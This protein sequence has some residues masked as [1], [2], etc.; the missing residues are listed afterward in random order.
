MKTATKWIRVT[1]ASPCPVCLKPDYC[2]YSADGVVARCMR[3][4]SAKESNGGWIHMLS[5]PRRPLPPPMPDR[6]VGPPP[7]F[8]QIMDALRYD[9]TRPMLSALA[10]S[11]GVSISALDA[12]DASWWAA[13][14][15]W[16]F[17]MLDDTGKAVGVRLRNDK[18]RKWAIP[19]SKQGLF[20]D[21]RMKASGDRVFYVCEGPTDTAALLT[22]GYPACG[23]AS[24][25]GQVDHV[26]G[27]CERLGF[28]RLII[29]SDNDAAKVRHDGSLWY[30]GAEGARA[31]ADA[32]G[33][34]Y[35]IVLPPAKDIRQWLR[36]GAT[37]AAFDCIERQQLW[38][39]SPCQAGS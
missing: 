8:A 17:P 31:L 3:V 7:D 16:A 1:K 15:T 24:C 2:G 39:K 28:K 32:C 5:E 27:L 37:R 11:L 25:A 14:K 30:P 12:L 33:M 29:V 36:D 4:P 20:Y 38:R 35:K 18:G 19:G 21:P 26:T 34:P 22:M 9:T 6:P 23:R 10:E 13:S